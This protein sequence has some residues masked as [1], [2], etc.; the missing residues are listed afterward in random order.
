MQLDP[1]ISHEKN[2]NSSTILSHARR[3]PC[4]TASA[5]QWLGGEGKIGKSHSWEYGEYIHIYMYVCMYVCMYIYIYT[6]DNEYVYN[7]I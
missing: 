3:K 4:Q 2:N 5:V 1:S 7:L 6:Y